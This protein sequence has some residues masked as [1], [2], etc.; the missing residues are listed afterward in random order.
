MFQPK[1][2][3]LAELD[4]LMLRKS[5]NSY[6]GAFKPSLWPTEASVQWLT[7]SGI[8]I[9]EGGC[10][11]AIWYR[12]NQHPATDQPVTRMRW[13]WEAGRWWEDHCNELYA[14]TGNLAGV[15]V[16][17]WDNSLQLPLSGELDAVHKLPD[18]GEHYVVDYKTSGGNYQGNIKILG[19]TKVIPYPKIN[20]LLQMMVYLKIDPRLRFAI[21]V[22]LIRDKMERTQ[23]QIE[24]A[25]HLETGLNVAYVNGV[26]D[27][28][29]SIEEIWRRYELLCYYYETQIMPPPDYE[30]TYSIEKAEALH[31][32]GLLSKTAFENHT[33]GKLA[34][35]WMCSYC[36]Y[37]TICKSNK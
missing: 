18:T 34:G 36:S 27:P 29:Y 21:L 4:D 2:N 14:L 12:L 6:R 28:R 7:A 20:A 26:P 13:V 31:Q 33:K 11:R 16:K 3:V 23:F 19:S 5:D 24:I 8:T 22:Y 1:A 37:R 30:E 25:P 17:V 35:D 10:H 9:T 32:E 15:K